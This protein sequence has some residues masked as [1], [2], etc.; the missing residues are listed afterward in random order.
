M[1]VYTTN[2]P[3]TRNKLDDRLYRGYFILYAA[4]TGVIIYWNIEQ[5]FVI[6]RDHHDWFDEYNSCI[7][8]EDKHT[9]GSL[10]IQQYLESI[11]H[12][13]YLLNLIP[14]ELDLTSTPFC[15]A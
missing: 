11:F 10:L 14:C 4:I 9:P 2:G 1:R 15:D 12:N 13:S 6:H 7:F 3:V 8:I 5:P